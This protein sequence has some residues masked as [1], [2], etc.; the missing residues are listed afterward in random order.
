MGNMTDEATKERYFIEVKGERSSW[1]EVGKTEF[2][3]HEGAAFFGAI[4]DIKSQI[5]AKEDIPQALVQGYSGSLWL[6]CSEMA[7]LPAALQYTRREGVSIRC[8]RHRTLP[9]L[10]EA[11]PGRKIVCVAHGGGAY[12]I[13]GQWILRYDLSFNPEEAQRHLDVK[14]AE[15]KAPR[16][17]G[18]R[19]RSR[20]SCGDLLAPMYSHIVDPIDKLTACNESTGAR[21]H[22]YYVMTYSPWNRYRYLKGIP[23]MAAFRDKMK[24]RNFRTKKWQAWV[25]TIVEKYMDDPEM[26][27]GFRTFIVREVARRR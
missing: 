12:V 4:D 14:A 21:Y 6:Q 2:A 25:D 13:D 18:R 20:M 26:T 16:G 9:I 27:S 7:D 24:L 10:R 11:L 23:V 19:A 17:R 1:K 15:V 5:A 3:N 8:G 22:Y